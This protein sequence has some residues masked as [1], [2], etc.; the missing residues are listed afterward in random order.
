MER[1]QLRSGASKKPWVCMARPEFPSQNAAATRGT[2][3]ASRGA[4]SPSATMG[5]DHCHG[6]SEPPAHSM[7]TASAGIS[8]GTRSGGG[9]CVTAQVTPCTGHLHGSAPGSATPPPDIKAVSHTSGH[10]SPARS[11]PSPCSSHPSPPGHSS[12]STFLT[13]LA[14]YTPKLTCRL[15]GSAPGTERGHPNP[16]HGTSGYLSPGSAQQSRPSHG[17]VLD[18]IGDNPWESG[19][20][21]ESCTLSFL[22]WLNALLKRANVNR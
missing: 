22:A 9:E 15:R 7:D 1:Q 3:A 10:H 17:C 14:T 13:A 18:F 21:G 6:P 11:L 20:R 12:P 16:Q 4:R 8:C 5:G 2:P 19:K